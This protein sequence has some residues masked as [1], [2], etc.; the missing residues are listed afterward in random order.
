MWDDG[1]EC[2]SEH[3]ITESDDVSST[4]YWS[5][6]ILDRMAQKNPMIASSAV[7]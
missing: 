1:V 5:G 7:M 2:R 4:G 6:D 3:N